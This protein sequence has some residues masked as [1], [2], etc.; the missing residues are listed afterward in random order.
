MNFI[1]IIFC[2]SS[3]P[4][5][6][7]VHQSS[8]PALRRGLTS[9]FIVL[10]LICVLES[11]GNYN[12]VAEVYVHVC[13]RARRKYN[14]ICLCAYKREVYDLAHDYRHDEWCTRTACCYDSAPRDGFITG[15]F[16]G[17]VCRE[18]SESHY[19]NVFPHVFLP[20]LTRKLSS[21]TIAADVITAIWIRVPTW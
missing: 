6:L 8:N 15:I 3:L 17:S 7:L 18:R 12:A 16:A 10:V 14:I 5:F 4:A 19:Y 13:A 9:G 20:T 2:V 11:S 1:Y 21:F